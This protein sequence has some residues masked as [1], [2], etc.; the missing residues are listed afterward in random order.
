MKGRLMYM[1]LVFSEN[2][3]KWFLAFVLFVIGFLEYFRRFVED[4]G[5]REIIPDAQFAFYLAFF[6][7]AIL[8]SFQREMIRISSHWYSL[9]IIGIAVFNFMLIMLFP[10]GGHLNKLDNS[11]YIMKYFLATLLMIS[12]I[13]SQVLVSIM[14]RLY[15]FAFLVGIVFMGV[16][17]L[18]YI[19][20]N[21]ILNENTIGFFLAPFLI[22]LFIKYQN[23]KYRFI[24][25]LAGSLLIYYSD[26]KTTLAAYMLLPVF[27]FAHQK[28]S[29]P[30]L[31]FTLL[32][33]FGAICVAIPTYIPSPVFT[34]LLTNRDILWT[35]YM[36]NVTQDMTSF[37]FGTGSWGPKVIGVERF[38]GMK[39]HNTFIS[40]LHLNGVIA[41]AGYVC[42]ILFGIRKS[43]R[44]FTMSDG[45]LFLTLTFQLAE[46]NVPLFSFVFPTF[47]FMVN[48]FLNKDSE[49]T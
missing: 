29:R 17:A 8:F 7:M 20:P 37:L 35:A 10:E 4:E 44:S 22:Y 12:V 49:L 27:S 18:G 38:E 11:L 6:V 42:F 2:V 33:F 13:R 23:P 5:I 19:G 9:F 31:L 39:A 45:I 21:E 48:I 26:A 30:R 25:Y 14:N 24:I 36:K 43:G 3:K 47:I 46:S 16:T 15:F 28:L 41:L 34:D 32:L 1:G 40:F